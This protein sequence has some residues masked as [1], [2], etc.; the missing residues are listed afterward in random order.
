MKR[1]II[2][3]AEMMKN[4][5]SEQIDAL[6]IQ[7][8]E[9]NTLYSGQTI[10]D[11]LSEYSDRFMICDEYTGF[12]AKWQMYI[13]YKLPDFL[14]AY[15][16]MY[17][18]Y[19]PLEN[20]SKHEN[21]VETIIDGDT[22]HTHTPDAEH[23]TKT[24]A[25]SYDY[26]VENIQ[27]A[28]NKPTTEHYVSTFDGV[29]KLESKNI[30]Q[31]KTTTNNKTNNDTEQTTTDDLKYVDTESHTTVTTTWNGTSYTA[32]KIKGYKNDISGLNG[33]TNQKLILD[34]LELAKHSLIYSFICEFISKY[35]FY[36]AGG[37][38]YDL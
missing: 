27:D 18:N 6:V 31:G 34:S 13:N 33:V 19:N 15:V 28:A 4:W 9:S 5:T 30:S 32:D 8:T 3:L 10:Y 23:N 36:A 22:T 14:K 24:T 21:G 2:Q 38:C 12:F 1:K 37:D 35:T 7:D 29:E 20:F 25:T 11:M 26:T 16:A 17:S